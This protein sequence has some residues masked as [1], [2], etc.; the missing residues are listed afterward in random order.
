VTQ[1]TAAGGPP[2]PGEPPD[3]APA[4]VGELR[5]LR[6]WVL[7]AG[8]WALAATAVG[9]IALLADDDPEPAR[10]E[11][12]TREAQQVEQSLGRRIDELESQLED[13]D[14][15]GDLRRLNRRLQQLEDDVAQAADDASRASDSAE[16]LGGRIDDL[17]GRVDALAAEGDGGPDPGSGEG[18]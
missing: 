17:E 1:P 11:S 9:L 15:S 5:T 16:E 4:T 10:E 13:A 12:G 6:R 14:T 8:V 7:V 3:D 2:P 18:Q